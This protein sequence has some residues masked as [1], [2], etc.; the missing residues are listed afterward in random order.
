MLCITSSPQTH[1]CPCMQGYKT[2]H[3]VKTPSA[4]KTQGQTTPTV[5]PNDCYG[6]QNP[7][8]LWVGYTGIWVWV[9]FIWPSLYLYPW[10]KLVVTRQVGVGFL[11]W[12]LNQDQPFGYGWSCFPPLPQHPSGL[13][14]HGRTCLKVSNILHILP[15]TIFRH[16]LDT[17]NFS[18][19]FY[20]GG[21]LMMS[22]RIRSRGGLVTLASQ[23][24]GQVQ[25]RLGG[26]TVLL[27][28]TCHRIWVWHWKGNWPDSGRDINSKYQNHLTSMPLTRT[29]K[30]EIMTCHIKAFGAIWFDPL[31]S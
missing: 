13:N 25:E 29:S 4:R 7:C 28:P 31:G 10:C 30:I 20:I 17:E 3:G 14:K 27:T 6:F 19:C 22:W 5:A 9:G 24:V 26:K 12:S 2:Q 11:Q 8:R 23:A 15:K 1:W 21:E 16:I 18:H